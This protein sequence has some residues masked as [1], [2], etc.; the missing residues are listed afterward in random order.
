MKQETVIK[1]NGIGAI[2]RFVTP[3]M[4]GILMA[5]V[6]QDMN[7]RKAMELKVDNINI[8]LNNHLQHDVADIKSSLMRI[9]AI[10]QRVERLERNING[11]SH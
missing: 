1:V 4:V 5:M 10:D 2:L 6:A 8:S 3:V 9:E 11:R 7:M